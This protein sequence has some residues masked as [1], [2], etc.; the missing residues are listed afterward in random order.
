MDSL[1]ITFAK[2]PHARDVKTRLKPILTRTERGQLQSAFIVDTLSS[3]ASLSVRQTLACAP[4]IHD[5]FF[6]QCQGNFNVMLIKQK[7]KDLGKRM[8]NAFLWGFAQG[9]KRVILIGSDSPTLPVS[10]IS[11]AFEQLLTFPVVLG[12]STDGGYYLIGA[13]PALPDLFRGIS[14]GSCTVLLETMKRLNRY[15]LL[16]FWYDIDRPNDLAF[17]KEHLAFLKN[18]RAHLPQ[19]TIEVI[20]SIPPDCFII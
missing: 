13:T 16:P 1:L 12:P 20:R 19:K 7:G 2:S 8:Q 6:I 11:E 15:Y 3:T 9:F 14:W 4:D 5:P 10:Y 17:L 18:E